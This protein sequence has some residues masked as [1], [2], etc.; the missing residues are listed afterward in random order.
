MTV[1]W[2]HGTFTDMEAS[3]EFPKKSFLFSIPLW[4]F[5]ARVYLGS[6]GL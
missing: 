6:D 3:D 4:E 5:I 1:F 2:V